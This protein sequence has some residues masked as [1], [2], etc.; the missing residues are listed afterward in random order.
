MVGHSCTDLEV[1]GDEKERERSLLE[2]AAEEPFIVVD[3]YL[4]HNYRI[5]SGKDCGPFVPQRS[6]NEQAGIEY[7]PDAVEIVL[8]TLQP[9]FLAVICM[10]FELS[11]HSLSR[12]SETFPVS[13]TFI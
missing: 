1:L 12:Q 2:G 7:N 10:C 11:L 13:T 5:L 3:H 9:Q 4:T 6:A 8:T